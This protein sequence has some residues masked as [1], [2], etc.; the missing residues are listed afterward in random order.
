VRNVLLTFCNVSWQKGSAAQVISLASQVQKI[1]PGTQ[2]TLLSHCADL[3]KSPAEQ[4]GIKVA[5]YPPGGS[6]NR[7]SV[8]LMWSRL[9]LTALSRY[10][11]Q[12]PLPKD[13]VAAAYRNADLVLD[14]S[15]DSYRDPP[16]GRSFP[17]N[18]NILACRALQIPCAIVSQSMGPFSWHT[19]RLTRHALN[20]LQSIYVRERRSIRILE[21]LGVR[22]E[23]LQLAPDIAFVLPPA[24][25]AEVD[26][27]FAREFHTVVLPRPWVGIS[28]NAFLSS[29]TFGALQLDA[30]FIRLVSH[31]HRKLRG[32]IFLIPHVIIPNKFD[33]LKAAENISTI[34]GR[35]AW[36]HCLKGNY[37]PSLLKGVI[38]RCDAFVASRLHAGI[39][40]LSSAVPTM[41]ASWS[42]KYEGLMEQVGIPEYVWNVQTP[43][44]GSEEIFDRLWRHRAAVRAQLELFNITAEAEI[45]KCLS[46]ILS[47]AL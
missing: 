39:A 24:T 1:R 34:L 47:G 43:Q 22:T 5:G 13:A 4:L 15:G 31:I 21:R 32:T 16:G 28:T 12:S 26:D 36:L 30:Q 38:A 40:A 19:R 2:L 33:D 6:V 46:R 44:V 25:E 29:R 9:R 37:G 17:H 11:R 42:H 45:Q 3:D 23:L 27:V 10:Y 41:M 20:G 35:P 18:A 8:H 14:M 7:R